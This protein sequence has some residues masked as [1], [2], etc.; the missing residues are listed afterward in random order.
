MIWLVLSFVLSFI[1]I[2][3][4][5]R[6]RFRKRIPVSLKYHFEF[7]RD[8]VFSGE[9]LYLD[10]VIENV[11]DRD[12]SFLQFETTLP[13]GL[14]FVFDTDGG[15]IRYE[16]TAA[17]VSDLAAHS[18][19]SRRWRVTAAKRGRY[20]SEQVLL[21]WITND[22][23]GLDELSDKIDP[24]PSKKGILTVLPRALDNISELILTPTFTG[25]RTVENGLLD[26]PMSFCG[27]RDYDVHDPFRSIAW[28]QSARL[29]R[30]VVH[31]H[32]TPRDDRFNIVLNMQS[33]IIEPRPP[34]LDAPEKIEPCISVA[35]SLLDH[36]MRQGVTTRLIANTDPDGLPG[37]PLRGDGTGSRIFA[38]DEFSEKD[39]VMQAW[40]VLAQLPPRISVTVEQM[41]DDILANP[42]YYVRDG[43]IIFVS[44]F[45]N[46]RMLNFHR[47]MKEKGL[48]V[49]FYTCGSRH[50]YARFPGDVEIYVK[51]L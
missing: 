44:A 48:K 20:T 43:N 30:L 3:L 12:I 7:D 32:E 25:T 36:F 19:L 46:D 28:K 5:G 39:G 23:L 31:R 14:R 33:V 9:T 41:M 18:R 29:G 10:Q 13:D 16:S 51:Y 1:A 21:H 40:R 24:E 11:T 37:S 6:K 42:E 22:A 17:N 50:E 49:V 27:I 47:L 45:I 4:I 26:D 34:E 2:Y 35:A 38:S 15:K 8:E